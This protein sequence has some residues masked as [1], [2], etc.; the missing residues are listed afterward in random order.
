MARDEWTEGKGTCGAARLGSGGAT[1][2]SKEAAGGGALE[3][4]AGGDRFR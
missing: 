4:A 2:S 1:L 3:R